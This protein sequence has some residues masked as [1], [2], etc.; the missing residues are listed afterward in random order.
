VCSKHFLVPKGFRQN[1]VGDGNAVAHPIYIAF[2][3]G[4]ANDRLQQPC[5]GVLLL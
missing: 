1:R 2:A 5:D 4:L 3:P